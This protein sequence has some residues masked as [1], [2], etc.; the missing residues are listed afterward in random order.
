MAIEDPDEIPL[1]GELDGE[2]EAPFR[3]RQ[4]AVPVRRGRFARGRRLLRWTLLAVFVLPLIVYA[5][6]GKWETGERRERFPAV[7]RREE[8]AG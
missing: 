2:E 8:V 3:R 5:G 1:P 7:A 6:Y 4:R